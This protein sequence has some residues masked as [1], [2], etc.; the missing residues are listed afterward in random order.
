MD[1]HNLRIPA[2]LLTYGTSRYILLMDGLDDMMDVSEG[3]PGGWWMDR[4]GGGFGVS[5][6]I[7]ICE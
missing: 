5:A 3:T 6:L 1:R 7:V 4:D 2:S